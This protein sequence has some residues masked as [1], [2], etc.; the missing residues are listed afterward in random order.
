[1]K[2]YICKKCTSNDIE[3]TEVFQIF[4]Y[5]IKFNKIEAKK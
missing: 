2:E 3:I 5:K 4:G 1:M